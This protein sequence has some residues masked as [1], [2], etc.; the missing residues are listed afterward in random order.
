MRYPFSP[1]VWVYCQFKL[2]GPPNALHT[3]PKLVGTGSVGVGV[4]VGVGVLVLVGV[5][6]GVGVGVFVPAGAVHSSRH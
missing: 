6:V 2:T 5:A 4:R 3:P 1:F